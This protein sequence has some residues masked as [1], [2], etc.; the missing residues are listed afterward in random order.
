MLQLAFDKWRCRR[1]RRR[2]GKAEDISYLRELNGRQLAK[3]IEQTQKKAI[4][5]AF[6]ELKTHGNRTGKTITEVR[7]LVSSAKV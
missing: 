6:W 1:P 5:D 2:A 7:K 3:A 4:L